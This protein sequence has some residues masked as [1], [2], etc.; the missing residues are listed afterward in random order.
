MK[1]HGSTRDTATQALVPTALLLALLGLAVPGFA[2]S[3]LSSATPCTLISGTRPVFVALVLRDGGSGW[4][5][6]TTRLRI[7]ERLANASTLPDEMEIGT[8]AGTSC[9]R[10]LRMGERYVV[11]AEASAA[12]GFDWSVSG[13]NPT[14]ALRDNEHQLDALRNAASQ[15]PARLIGIVHQLENN[16]R[17][18][19]RVPG[20]TVTATSPDREYSVVTD[21]SGVFTIPGILPG[22]YRME[23]AKPGYLPNS[24]YN[25]RWSG[26]LVFNQETRR[27]APD[28]EEK[29]S[30]PVLI[31]E[32]ACTEWDL[33]VWVDQTV[34]GRI[35]DQ[36]GAPVSDVQVQAFSIGERGDQSSFPLRTAKTDANGEYT[37]RP[38]PDGDYI[39][40]VNASRWDDTA[41]YPT[42]KFPGRVSVAGPPFPTVNLTLPPKRS[43]T[44]LQIQVAGPDGAPLAGAEVILTDSAGRRHATPEAKTSPAGTLSV[45]VYSGETYVVKVRHSPSGRMESNDLGGEV[46]VSIN[47][48]NP[49]AIVLL[50]PGRF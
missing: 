23:V 32:R 43:T 30:G 34:S 40:G 25:S 15:G 35:V 9:Y 17:P 2:C 48:P 39:I 7:E 21:G 45:P 42:T 29:V 27:S 22:R 38:L 14:F 26:R 46:R 44:S 33:G 5:E 28:P 18:A 20:A 8:A 24:T 6:G 4:G 47:T 50:A 10:R 12:K 31:T 41:P 19:P 13:C 36:R 16:N 3:C 49:M 37:L 11:F 1:L